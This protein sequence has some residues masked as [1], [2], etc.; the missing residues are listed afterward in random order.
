MD[1][2]LGKIRSRELAA[3][4]AFFDANGDATWKIVACHHPL[5]DLSNTRVR[6]KT[7]GGKE[8]LDAF[9]AC[10]VN[11]V[12]SGH[13]HVP[14][15]ASFEHSAGTISLI[16]AGTLSERTRENQSSFNRLFI[17][18]QSATVVQY[19]IAGEKVRE[20]RRNVI[21]SESDR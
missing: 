7:T 15:L 8:A 5:V 17:T 16:S 6:G 20:V 1:W 21:E 10:G 14:G 18:P 19:G 12:L 4:V 3:A 2:S 9:A 11:L 13:T